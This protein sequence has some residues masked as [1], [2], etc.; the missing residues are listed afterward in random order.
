MKLIAVSQRVDASPY[1][2]EKRDGLDQRWWPLLQAADLCPLILPNQ[3][4]L[5]QALISHCQPEGVLLTGG[6]SHLSCQGDAPER[7]ALDSWLIDW[8]QAENKPLLGICRGMQSLQIAFGLNLE[9]VENQCQ[10]QQQV[11]IEGQWHEV[12]SYHDWGTRQHLPGFETWATEQNGV[13]K[14]IRHPQ[15]PLWGIMWHPERLQPYREADIKLFRQ[16]FGT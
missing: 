7:D 1:Y 3:L 2:A 9:R 5:A 11:C 8:V 15:L 12:N 6:N 10:A 14:A 16:V 13:I 4:E